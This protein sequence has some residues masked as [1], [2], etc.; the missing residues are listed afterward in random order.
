MFFRS[1]GSA[2][3]PPAFAGE[4][5][6]V[7]AVGQR[8]HP[9]LELGRVIRPVIRGGFELPGVAPGEDAGAGGRAFGVGRIGVEE[10]DARLAKRSK[11]GVL[12]QRVP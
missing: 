7:A 2:P 5:D 6:E 11:F 10:Q 3:G 4:P 9:A 1:G 12:T 8:L